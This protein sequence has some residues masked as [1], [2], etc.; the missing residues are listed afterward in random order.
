MTC[1]S[2]G[3]RTP[4]VLLPYTDSA[5]TQ[6]GLDHPESESE[7][8]V[9]LFVRLMISGSRADVPVPLA[10]VRPLRLGID[11]EPRQVGD[12]KLGFVVGAALVGLGLA[13]LV[14]T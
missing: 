11:R 10:P 4:P 1:V 2:S 6:I 14:Y 3:P 9:E 8:E 5:E 7:G 13:H 12:V